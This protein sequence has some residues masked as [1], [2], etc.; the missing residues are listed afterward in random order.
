MLQ[1][2]GKEFGLYSGEDERV[3]RQQRQSDGKRADQ[4][5]VIAFDAPLRIEQQGRR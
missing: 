5:Q 3:N 1:P 4:C 2:E